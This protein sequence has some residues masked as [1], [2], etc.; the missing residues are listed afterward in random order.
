MLIWIN[1]SLDR[2]WS[3]K[4]HETTKLT[5]SFV[6]FFIEQSIVDDDDD[7]IIG[8]MVDLTFSIFRFTICWS[9]KSKII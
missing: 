3:C 1:R 4:K 9:I 8:R 6:P 5:R 2:K 7:K